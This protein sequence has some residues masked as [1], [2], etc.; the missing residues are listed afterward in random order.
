MLPN[1]LIMHCDFHLVNDS[2]E[3]FAFFLAWHLML[4]GEH[5]VKLASLNCMILSPNRK[6]KHIKGLWIHTNS[7]H[8][9]FF[10]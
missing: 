7:R 10:D 8:W 1:Y 4:F 3:T 6:A 5:H 9:D 2:K